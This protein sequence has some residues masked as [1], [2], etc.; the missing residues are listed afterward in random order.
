MRCPGWTGNLRSGTCYPEE[1][2][3][4]SMGPRRPALE[5]ADIRLGGPRAPR[6]A[7]AWAR[8]LWIYR[9]EEGRRRR[10]AQPHPAPLPRADGRP[11]SRSDAPGLRL[12]NHSPYRRHRPRLSRSSVG[13][14]FSSHP[15]SSTPGAK[16][17]GIEECMT[18][19]FAFGCSRSIGTSAQMSAGAAHRLFAV[20]SI[21]QRERR[22]EDQ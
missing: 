2:Q 4:I 19:D 16:A 8:P 10:S 5:C 17:P 1:A 7:R 11:A 3:R 15:R 9:V 18:S 20:G 22:A 13:P 12:R 14:R 21:G 6:R